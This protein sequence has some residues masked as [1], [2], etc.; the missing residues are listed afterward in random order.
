[1]GYWYDQ[2]GSASVVTMLSRT[3]VIPP[4]TIMMTLSSV[5]FPYRLAAVMAA[6]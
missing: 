3:E 1:M 5:F 4:I 6:R 2:L